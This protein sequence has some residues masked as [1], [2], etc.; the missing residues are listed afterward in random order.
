MVQD[1]ILRFSLSSDVFPF[2]LALC[3]YIFQQASGKGMIKVYFESVAW[4]TTP[5]FKI[6]FLRVS[7]QK[8]HLIKM[9]GGKSIKTLVLSCQA[10]F[11]LKHY[12]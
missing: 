12:W 7:S 9:V 10:D 2:L 4:T 5:L 1:K 6:C 11:I 8:D 3:K